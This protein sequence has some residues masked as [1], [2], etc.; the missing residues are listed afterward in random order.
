MISRKRILNPASLLLKAIE[1]ELLEM[2]EHTGGTMRI[3][4]GLPLVYA[5]KN[6]ITIIFHNLITNALKY[7]DAARQVS[8]YRFS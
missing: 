5:D 7:N 1:H 6:K 8:D 4:T 3:E 2:L